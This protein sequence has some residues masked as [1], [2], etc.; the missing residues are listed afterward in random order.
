MPLTY[1]NEPR[2]Q[3]IPERPTLSELKDMYDL[4]DFMHLEHEKEYSNYKIGLCP[5][6]DDTRPSMKVGPRYYTCYA[7]GEWGSIFDWYQHLMPGAEWWEV[8][9]RIV[10][11][12]QGFAVSN[13]SP[14]VGKPRVKVPEVEP[15]PEPLPVSYLDGF[16]RSLKARPDVLKRMMAKW[17]LPESTIRR[18]K[19]GYCVTRRAFVIPVWGK[20]YDTLLTVRFRRDDWEHDKLKM[21]TIRTDNGKKQYTYPRYSGLK[22]RNGVY[23]YNRAMLSDGAAVLLTF[24]EMTAR[25][26]TDVFGLRAVSQTNGAWAFRRYLMPLFAN[27]EE[28]TVVPD[29]PKPN[30]QKQ[31]EVDAAFR[32]ARMFEGRAKVLVP[33]DDVPPGDVIDWYQAGRMTRNRFF[34]ELISA[35]RPGEVVRRQNNELWVR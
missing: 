12:A 31:D 3:E 4:R 16:L 24:G 33:P 14:S 7:C 13:G 34:R 5:F 15:L 28:I 17:S 26:L 8:V 35:I 27:V 11:D 9:D 22:G 19:M 10:G 21:F 23:L 32:V 6:H 30:P 18:E 25:F 29:K 20:D 1:T 2:R